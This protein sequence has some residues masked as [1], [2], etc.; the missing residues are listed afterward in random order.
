MVQ[1]SLRFQ[2]P[3]LQ[4]LGD[5]NFTITSITN[6]TSG[7]NNLSEDASATFQ[8]FPIPDVSGATINATS[9]CLNFS[10]EVFI[11]GAINLSDGIYTINYQL[12]GANSSTSSSSVTFV[13]G[14]GSFIIPATDLNNSGN[15]TITVTQLTSNVSQCG[16]SASVINPFTFVCYGT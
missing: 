4:T 14:R 9:A 16:S 13:N 7:C 8:V 1:D 3:I 11:T 12:S 10:N 6:L 2:L 15:V 5:Y